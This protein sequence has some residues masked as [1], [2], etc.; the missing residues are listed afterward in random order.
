MSE[1]RAS[2]T[3]SKF[4]FLTVITLGIYP[5]FY[6]KDLSA[7]IN[8]ICR[9]DGKETAG[10]VKYIFFSIITLG[11]YAIYWHYSLGKR[12]KDSAKSKYR[13]TLGESGGTYLLCIIPGAFF[14][15]VGLIVLWYFIIKNTNRLACAYNI[16]MRSNAKANAPAKANAKSTAPAQQKPKNYGK[17][18]EGKNYVTLTKQNGENVRFLEIAGVAYNGK[19]YSI[20]Q[21][22]KLLS[23]M[24]SDEALVFR[25]TRMQNGEDNFELEMNDAIVD[26]VFKI[27]GSLV[28]KK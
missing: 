7:D 12:M 25:V 28:A 8:R 22:E 24:K 15:G 3:L 18:A 20:L 4:L 16:K 2:R 11:I 9:G 5:L 23:G 27:Y 10:A 14:F 1:I 19:F 17:L 13:L 21:P 26:A 6:I